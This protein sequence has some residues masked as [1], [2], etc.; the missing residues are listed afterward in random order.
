MI[1]VPVPGDG[2]SF[3]EDLHDYKD[4]ETFG[5]GLQA[6]AKANHGWLGFYFVSE[7]ARALASDRA[8]V[9][10]FFEARRRAYKR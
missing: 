5:V 7:L 8:E 1:E 4:L 2:S 9:V 10:R 6:L 3:F